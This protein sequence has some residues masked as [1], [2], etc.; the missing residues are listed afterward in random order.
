MNAYTFTR[1]TLLS[2]A[3]AACS[4]YAT[5]PTMVSE[6][7]LT[8]GNGM[9]LYTFDRDAAGVELARGLANYAA[10]EAR[11]LCRRSSTDIEG[12][13]GYSAEPEMIHRDNLVLM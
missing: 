6:G 5:R 1:I 3:L 11:L 4:A 2:A 13:L 9:T 8:G 10:A 7:M 12:L